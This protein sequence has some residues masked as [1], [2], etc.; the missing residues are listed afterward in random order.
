MISIHVTNK[1][2]VPRLFKKKKLLGKCKSSPNESS[3]HTHQ[4][5][6]NEKENLIKSSVSERE[7][8]GP[9]VVCCWELKPEHD[10]G[11]QLALSGEAEGAH[12]PMFQRSHS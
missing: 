10:F 6:Q 12:T 11:K 5:G 3:F 4:T 2:L 8:T 1:R 7:N 9:C